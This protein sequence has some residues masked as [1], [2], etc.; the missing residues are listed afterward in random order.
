MQLA[1]PT[2][3]SSAC[4]RRRR[5]EGVVG[6][7]G[8]QLGRQT[9]PGQP[10]G[11]VERAAAR[12]GRVQTAFVGYQVDERFTQHGQHGAQA[13]L[14]RNAITLE[15]LAMDVSPGVAEDDDAPTAASFVGRR[16]M[17][18]MLVDAAGLYF[19]AF[20]GVPTSITAPDGRPVNAIRGFLDM[21]AT[22]I[23]RRRPTRFVACQDLS[24]RPAFRV[25]LLPSYKAHRALADGAEIVPDELSPQVPVL[26]EVLDAIGLARAGADGF[27]ADDVMATLAAARAR[28]GGD[29]QRRSGSVRLCQRSRP[30][31]VRGPRGVEAAGSRPGRGRREVRHPG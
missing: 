13:N 3:L 26:W 19:R 9:E 4:A 6:Q 1:V 29:R 24:W 30:G 16:S 12:S 27:E 23:T 22:L 14:L 10:D 2:W 20:H 25:A 7:P 31:A 5:P 11:H 15:V 28:P 17:S 18:L 8:Q 21:T